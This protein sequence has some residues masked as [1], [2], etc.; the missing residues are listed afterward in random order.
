MRVLSVFARVRAHQT[1][2]MAVGAKATAF[3][4]GA[5]GFIGTELIKVLK[6]NGHHVF[7]LTWSLDAARRVRDAGATPVMGN[8]LE[9]GQWQDEARAEWVFHLP[10]H[11]REAT[12]SPWTRAATATRERLLMGKATQIESLDL[13]RFHRR[14]PA[15]LL[16][17]ALI[18]CSD[19]GYRKSGIYPKSMSPGTAAASSV[20]VTDVPLATWR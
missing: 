18:S 16:E 12:G 11:P 17:Y 6:S 10:P 3:V 20:R 8:L 13:N 9:P 2:G 19:R 7:G 5:A 14:F 1:A 15:L 4:T